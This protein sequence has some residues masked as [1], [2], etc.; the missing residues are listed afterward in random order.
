MKLF[1]RT[2]PTL[3]LALALTVPASRAA[4]QAFGF[5]TE[6]DPEDTTAAPDRT[7]VSATVTVH[8]KLVLGAT[9]F[10]E[11]LSDPAAE[12]ENASAA[13]VDLTA[14]GTSAY[15]ALRLR[16]AEPALDAAT[17]ADF[18]D[19]AVEEA[20]LR[21]FLG[22]VT[23]EGGIRKLSW[24]KADSQGPLDVVN[25]LDLTDLTVTDDLERR[26]ARPLVRV[27]W[28]A[29]LLTQVEAVFLPSFAGHDIAWDGRWSPAALDTVKYYV[30]LGAS[31]TTPTTDS[32]NYAQAGLRFSTTTGSVD[33]GLQYFYGLLPKPA[34]DLTGLPATI[35]VLYNRYHQAGADLAAV[36]GGF[37]LRAELA[38]NLT[39]DLSGDDPLVYNPHLAFSLGADRDVWKGLNLNLQYA[40]TIR[41][42]DGGISSPVDVETDTEAFRSGLTAVAFQK[43]LRDKLE[44]RVAALWNLS[45]ADFLISPSLSWTE[46]DAEVK[47]AAGIFGGDSDGQMGQYAEASWVRLTLA[48]TF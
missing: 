35:N 13:S 23:V 36:L 40:G 26:I 9:L 19:Q 21:L 15:A 11:D 25:P 4:A 24:G 32:L 3:L 43:L 39:E 48:Y 44:W 45:D 41:L 2:F 5:G 27:S 42:A 31:I 22:S 33:W 38:A 7:S 30:G 1:K 28:T 17:A 34:Y 37:G 18:L 29:G 47:L 12:P 16:I 10:P 20:F 6:P 8:G 14:S 46:G